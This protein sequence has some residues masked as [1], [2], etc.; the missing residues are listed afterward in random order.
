MNILIVEDDLETAELLVELLEVGSASTAHVPTGELALAHLREH[1]V[2]LVVLG[3]SP[4]CASSC[5]PHGARPRTAST[6]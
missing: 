3:R 6:A 4:P 2:D 5:C 1:P